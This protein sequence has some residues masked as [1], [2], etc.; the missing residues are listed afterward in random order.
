MRNWARVQAKTG[1]SKVYLYYFTRHAPKDAPFP[2]AYH[3]AELYYAFHNLHL[4]KQQW[5]EWDHKLADIISSYWVNFA[6][7]GDPNGKELPSWGPYD[8]T[9]GERAMVFG[10]QAEMGPARLEKA[11]LDL[12]DAQSARRR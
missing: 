11:K 4:Y 9:R 6:F 12:F 10:D 3:D 1:K 8:E 2:G 5:E 7:A